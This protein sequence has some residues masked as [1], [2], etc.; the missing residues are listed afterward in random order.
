MSSEQIELFISYSHRDET[1]RQQLDK[2]L[3]PLKRQGVISVWHDR[4]SS[5]WFS[6][7][8]DE[9]QFIQRLAIFL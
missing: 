2:H 4:S 6:L 9:N 1:L 5:G 8:S 3:A 7:G